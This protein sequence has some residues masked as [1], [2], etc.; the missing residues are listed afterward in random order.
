MHTALVWMLGGVWSSWTNQ[1]TVA[2]T[3]RGGY[4]LVVMVYLTFQSRC[5]KAVF[6]KYRWCWCKLMLAIKYDSH[7]TWSGLCGHVCVTSLPLQVQ[8]SVP[9]PWLDRPTKARTKWFSIRCSRRVGNLRHLCWVPE[10]VSE[11]SY[12]GWFCG[13]W[14][15]QNYWW[16]KSDG[17]RCAS[18]LAK[19]F[20]QWFL[21]RQ[22]ATDYHRWNP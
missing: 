1:K 15:S 19:W 6:S 11:D 13:G 9:W 14:K 21:V 4:G 20:T 10:Y 3:E 22:L 5:Q 8:A 12:N 17:R 16:F 7:S 18:R 2:R